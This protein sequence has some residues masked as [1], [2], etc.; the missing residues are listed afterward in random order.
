MRL[1]RSVAMGSAAADQAF[2]A[3][4]SVL[5]F[6]VQQSALDFAVRGSAGVVRVTLA[7]PAMVP[8]MLVAASLGVGPA[9]SVAAWH[10]VGMGPTAA[11]VIGP[12]A[13]MDG[14]GDGLLQRV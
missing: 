6:V 4:Q 9:T 3:L 11:M 1:S 8:A 13:G 2:V 10:G 5:A 12:I 7:A 14:V